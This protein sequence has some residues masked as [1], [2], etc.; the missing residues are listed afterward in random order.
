MA[1]NWMQPEF[2]MSVGDTEFNTADADG[3]VTVEPEI[4]FV[5][6]DRLEGPDEHGRGLAIGATDDVEAVVQAID[7]VDV[8]HARW[9][10]HHRRARRVPKVLADL[11]PLPRLVRQGL[12]RVSPSPAGFRQYGAA[13]WFS[14]A[15]PLPVPMPLAAQSPTLVTAA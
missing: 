3:L 5:M 8:G 7:E 9:A 13:M 15:T 12:S 10:E 14:P 11:S 1:L 6:G 2:V 4:V